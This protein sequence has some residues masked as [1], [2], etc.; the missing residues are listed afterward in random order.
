MKARAVAAN[1]QSWRLQ[2]VCHPA[3][4]HDPNTWFPPQPKP[5]STRAEARRATALRI[6]W[7]T[8]A[9][10]LCATCPVAR[11]CLEY[12]DDNDEREGVWG[13]LTVT[14]R[15]LTPLR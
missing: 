1:D 6:W 13:G 10:N 4:G 8:R 3:N 11:E 15:G 2:A 5:Y 9:K 12:A 7:E 14:E